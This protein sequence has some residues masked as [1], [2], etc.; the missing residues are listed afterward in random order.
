MGLIEISRNGRAFLVDEATDRSYRDIDDAIH[1]SFWQE[2]KNGDWEPE[3]FLA[4]ERF[5][6]S[7][8]VF[9][10]LGAWIGPTA[11]YAAQI[12]KHVFAFEPDPVALDA[13]EKNVAANPDLASRITIFPLALGDDNGKITLYNDNFGSSETSIFDLHKRGGSVRKITGNFNAEAVD[14]L[15]VMK[16]LCSLRNVFIKCDIEGAEYSL[17]DRSFRLLSVVKPSILISHHVE[18]L[19]IRG[20]VKFDLFRKKIMNMRLLE[21]L[22]RFDEV[23]QFSVDSWT[24]YSWDLAVNDLQSEKGIPSPLFIRGAYD[25]ELSSG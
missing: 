17:L 23:Y 22:Q 2:Y 13:L 19:N 12:A 3:T 5:L 4:F 9:V 6:T 11:I 7:D 16:M 21:F 14:S 24:P 18:N 25:N 15:A 8:H 1:P 10:D 20:N